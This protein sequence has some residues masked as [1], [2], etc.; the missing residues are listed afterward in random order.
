[1]A[2]CKSKTEGINIETEP[3]FHNKNDFNIIWFRHESIVKRT[4][5]IKLENHAYFLLTSGASCY[6]NI[7]NKIER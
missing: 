3:F 7:L 4:N 6:I 2:F 1:M 5:E